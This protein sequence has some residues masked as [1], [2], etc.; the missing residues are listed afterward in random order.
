MLPVDEEA[1]VAVVL[2]IFVDNTR[3][4]S[5]VGILL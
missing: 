2:A 3:K 5:D 4:Q 1:V